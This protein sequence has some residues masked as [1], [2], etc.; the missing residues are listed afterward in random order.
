[1]TQRT[2]FITGA[3]GAAVP[4]LIKLLKQKGIRVIAGDMVRHAVGLYI[5]DKGFILPAGTSSHFF[6]TLKKI[7]R[8]EKVDA[9]IPLV[10]EELLSAIKLEEEGHLP[11]LLPQRNFTALCLDKY[12]LMNQLARHQIPV[13]KTKLASEGCEGLLFPIIAKPRVG[14]GSRGVK[15]LKTKEDFQAYCNGLDQLSSI[16]VQEYIPGKEF[17]VSVVVWRDGE[18]QS[19]IPKEIVHK[20]NIT[21]MAVTRRNEKVIRIC[22][23][24]QKEMKANGPFN[25]QLKLDPHGEPYIF[26]INPRFSTSVSLT[27]ASGIDELNVLLDQALTGRKASAPLVWKEGIVL[28]RQSLDECISEEDFLNRQTNIE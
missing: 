8:E 20:Q 17:T 5:A 15:V 4:G 12:Q 25:V 23:K 21:K 3:G 10:D 14:R 2:V 11:V 13:P 19:V 9:V 28:L 1:M 24:V 22:S 6:P 7:C 16:L 18:V 26:E 27:I